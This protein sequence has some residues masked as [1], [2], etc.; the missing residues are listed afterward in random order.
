[1]MNCGYDPDPSGFYETP[2]VAPQ[3]WHSYHI[4]RRS[5]RVQI[6]AALTYRN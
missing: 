5:D 6:I 1:M 3:M 2:P 4:R